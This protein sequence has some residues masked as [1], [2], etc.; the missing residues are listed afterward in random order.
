M[1][2][3]IRLLTLLTLLFIFCTARIGTGTATA[4]AVADLTCASST[5]LEALVTCI[6]NQMPQSR[7]NGYVAPT[8][9]Q[10][11]D[12]RTVV[13]QMLQGNCTVALPA[14]LTGIMRLST[15]SD[16]GNGR[17]YC[18]LMEVQNANNDGFV[19][20]GWGTFIVYNS[21][22]RQLSHQ[23]PHPISDSTTETQAVTVFKETDAR[24]YL[25]SGAH[26]NANPT[27]SSCQ[28]SYDVADAAHNTNNMFQATNLELLA[29]YGATDWTAIQ[30]HGMAVRTCVNTDVYP[31]H[32]RNVTPNPGDRIVRLRNN[33]LSYH[34]TWDIDLPGTGVCSLNGTDNTQGRLING[35]A[36][37]TEC[38]T[39][40]TTYNGRFIHIEQDPNF[41]NPADWVNPIRDTW[42][43]GP[44]AAP[45]GL[46]AL[47]GNAQVSLS[48][49][50]V[51]GA[52]SYSLHRS[53]ISG[54][55]YTTIAT[56]VMATSYLNTGLTNGVTYYYVVT[57][58]STSGE[59]PNSNQ[60]SATPTAPALPS[61]PT[62][63]TAMAGRKKVTL[64]WTVA[65]GATSYNIKRSTTNGG[66]Y[67][68]VA[69]GVTV[70]T[71]TNTG[72]T[73]GATYYY[74]VTAVNA[75][76]ESGNSN[77]AS[78]KAK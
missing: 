67:T 19:D 50:A 26:R 71:Y 25:L 10:Q 52:T 37:G 32:G 68:T 74:V 77:Q 58:L 20:R 75:V 13:G 24:S 31:S 45:T 42:P 36:A 17:N 66:P 18:V 70:T 55:S 6:R 63:L 64:N 34:P 76:G 41:R 39:A 16:A 47:A 27:A 5:T 43:A 35:V 54:G 33:V 53:T 73:T 30:W 61:I 12:W 38:S 65:S 69:T 59:S 9:A 78:A 2:K 21:A 7:S 11:N 72:L 3:T 44:P 48:W 8:A 23:A 4:S 46:S 29:H 14:S 62:N 60:A 28:S 1:S 22:T 57:A 40:A 51:N 15:F 56:G 49:T